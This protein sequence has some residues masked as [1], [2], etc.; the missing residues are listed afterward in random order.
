MADKILKNGTY[1]VTELRLPKNISVFVQDIAWGSLTEL[2]N[3]MFVTMDT[4]TGV[5]STP[6]IGDS[7]LFVHCVPKQYE[8]KNSASD[9]VA[10]K[11]SFLP[12]VIRLGKDSIIATDNVIVDDTVT[13]VA[14]F[15]A[16]ATYLATAANK[17]YG[18]VDVTTRRMRIAKSIPSTS[19]SIPAITFEVKAVTTLKTGETGLELIAL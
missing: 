6:A 17:L 11:G 1:G 12:R 13:E 14:S 7:V 8:G 4:K 16:M 18:Y 5:L 3:G 9:Y 10:K 19:G 15:S 2:E